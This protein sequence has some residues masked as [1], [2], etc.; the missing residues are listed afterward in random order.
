M[1]KFITKH[2]KIETYLPKFYIRGRGFRLSIDI[3]F[4]VDTKKH[5]YT[6]KVFGLG[7]AVSRV[8]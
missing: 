6:F 2:W 7:F 1:K 8:E 5:N 4:R 3:A